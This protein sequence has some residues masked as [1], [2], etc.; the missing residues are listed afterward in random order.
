MKI[1]ITGKEE[2]KVRTQGQENQVNFYSLFSMK[3]M[4][5]NRSNNPETTTGS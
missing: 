4:E 5:N 3:V 1:M 2:G